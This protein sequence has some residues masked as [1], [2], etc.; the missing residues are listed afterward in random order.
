MAPGSDFCFISISGVFI[1]DGKSDISRFAVFGIPKSGVNIAVTVSNLGVG[2][3][4]KRIFIKPDGFKGFGIEC[5]NGAVVESDKDKSFRI[6]KRADCVGGRTAGHFSGLDYFAAYLIDFHNGFAGVAIEI[7]VN[8]NRNAR[9][10]VII[11]GSDFVCPIKSGFFFYGRSGAV[12]YHVVIIVKSEERPAGIVFFKRNCRCFFKVHHNKSIA[13]GNIFRGFADISEGGYI[14][15][16]GFSFKKFKFSVCVCGNTLLK[17]IAD[18]NKGVFRVYAESDFCFCKFCYFKV[19]CFFKAFAVLYHNSNN[20]FAF[21][22]RNNVV[23]ASV[24]GNGVAFVI[25]DSGYGDFFFTGGSGIFGGADRKFFVERNC[26]S[27]QIRGGKTGKARGSFKFNG[28]GLNIAFNSDFK[29]DGVSD[30]AFVERPCEQNTFC[31]AGIYV[32]NLFGPFGFNKFC[33][34]GRTFRCVAGKFCLDENSVDAVLNFYVISENF[35]AQF[36]AHFKKFACCGFGKTE[37]GKIER[38]FG[39]GYLTFGGNVADFCGDSCFAL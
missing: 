10:A 22:K 38:K 14:I 13:G 2:L 37:F 30:R 33:S 20:V 31:V 15:G 12:D 6:G 5:L 23:F 24:I 9:C 26:V 18:I 34:D 11:T 29:S 19:I 3:T 36:R 7:I 16:I 4:F 27:V 35:V 25:G 21:G 1:G 17:F 32:Y 8:K 28:I 39:Y